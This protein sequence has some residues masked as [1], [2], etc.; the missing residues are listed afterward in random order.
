MNLGKYQADGVICDLAP[1][2]LSILLYWLDEPVV[3]VAATARSVFQDG[4][5]ETAFLTLTFASGA[6][7]NV[8]ISWLAPRKVREMIDRRQP[9][10]GPVRRHGRRRGRP[11]LRPRHGVLRRRRTS[12]STSSPTAAATS[13][14]RAWS[15]RAAQSRAR[16]LRARRSAPA[17]RRAR[18]PSSA[19]D[20]RRMEA[21]EESLRRNGEP[22]V[23]QR[24]T[25]ASRGL[26]E[27]R[28]PPGARYF[29]GRDGIGRPHPLYRGG[30]RE[31]T[32]LGHEYALRASVAERPIRAEASRPDRQPA[33]PLPPPR[34]TAA[35]RTARG[36]HRARGRKRCGD[37][38]GG[39]RWLQV[40]PVGRL[41]PLRTRHGP[42]RRADRGARLHRR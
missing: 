23:G 26:N 39:R 4:M 35:L 42:P 12:A 30:D 16:R 15:R 41:R 27:R 32:D 40:G 29:A 33:H 5:P 17:T 11:R 10:D 2:D 31:G 8:Q 21:A 19:R 24:G 13:S 7:A 34:V 20:R 9:A 25:G 18:T 38:G 1:H 14:S 22:V 37:D 36:H 3:E 6:T 28:A